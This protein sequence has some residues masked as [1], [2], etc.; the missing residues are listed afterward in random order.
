V[1][2][3]FTAPTSPVPSPEYRRTL[4][5]VKDAL[6]ATKQALVRTER[7]LEKLAAEKA[8]RYR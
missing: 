1:I 2:N 4:K 5:E 6:K 3:L 8:T 7:K